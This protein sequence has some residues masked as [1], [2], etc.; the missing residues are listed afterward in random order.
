MSIHR[1]YRELSELDPRD[2]RNAIWVVSPD[3]YNELRREFPATLFPLP[4]LVEVGK[5][6][7]AERPAMLLGIEVWVRSDLPPDTARLDVDD[8]VTR[9]IKRTNAREGERVT[10]NLVKVEPLPFISPPP[11]PE[12]TLRALVRKWAKRAQRK[13]AE[14]A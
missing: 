4:E 12:V 9:A 11:P 2:L 14:M 6:P 8:P 13:E 1:F 5:T 7:P 10:V 3:V